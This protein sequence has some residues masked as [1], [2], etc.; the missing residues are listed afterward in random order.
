[1]STAS[2]Q[3]S[4]S[5]SGYTNIKTLCPIAKEPD[6]SYAPYSREDV[7]GDG[8]VRGSGYP[9]AE[10]HFGYLTQTEHDALR[11]Y[12]SGKSANV[13]MVTK[14]N[15]NTYGTFTATMVWPD[16]VRFENSK[17]LDVTFKFLKLEAV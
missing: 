8:T 9:V 15:A 3:I 2:F 17:A 4:T 11:A 13:Y 10:W 1:M 6:W 12:C 16:N 5:T 14:T 7:L